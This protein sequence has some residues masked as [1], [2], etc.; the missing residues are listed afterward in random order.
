MKK[1]FLSA[2]LEVQKSL[3]VIKKE[4][5]GQV[6]H[7]KFMYSPLETIWEKVGKILN[8]NGFVIAHEIK[9]GE[10]ITSAYHEHGELH[11]SFSYGAL[12]DPKDIGIATT[13]GKR[14]NLVAIFNIQLENEDTDIEEIQ[15]KV[16]P[17]NEAKPW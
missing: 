11:S 10:V 1:E 12:V 17:A 4:K 8:D 3:P 13:Y 16:K 15:G 14:Y 7:R 2:L 9:S 6:G 5:E